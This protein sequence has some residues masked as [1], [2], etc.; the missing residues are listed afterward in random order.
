MPYVAIH[1]RVQDFNRWKSM[2]EASKAVREA[3]GI[4]EHLLRTDTA[5]NEAVLLVEHETLERARAWTESPQ[6]QAARQRGGVEQAT[7]YY[8][9]SWLR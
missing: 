6:V 2:W 7:V 5:T 3:A 4:H 8:P 1:I 9:E